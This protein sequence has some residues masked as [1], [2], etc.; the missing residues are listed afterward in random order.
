MELEMRRANICGRR[1]FL[2]F[3][4]GI[5][6][7]GAAAAQDLRTAVDN[8]SESSTPVTRRHSGMKAT[9]TYSCASSAIAYSPWRRSSA[10]VCQIQMRSTAGISISAVLAR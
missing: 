2:G 9:R 5:L 1:L 8:R 3:A 7:A 6:G 10:G 4:L